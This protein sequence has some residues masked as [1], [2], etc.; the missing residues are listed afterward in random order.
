MSVLPY[1]RADRVA[2]L[3]KEEI[4]RILAEEV[5]DPRIGMVTI[6]RVR[7]TDD[8]RYARVYF[9]VMGGAQKRDQSLTGLNRAKQFI[10]AE[11]RAHTDL[12]Y[13]PEVEFLYDDSLDYSERI[14]HLIAEIHRSK[15][16]D[17][18]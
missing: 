14:E 6:T 12:R 8:L 17:E 1:K 10:R 9:S 16:N 7:L 11:I 3:L 4:S 15:E 13:T 2:E 18:S 5:K